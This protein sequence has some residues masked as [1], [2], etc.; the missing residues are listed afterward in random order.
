MVTQSLKLYVTSLSNSVTE[1]L[2]MFQKYFQ[3][4]LVGLC[5]QATNYR[6]KARNIE[7]IILHHLKEFQFALVNV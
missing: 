6:I 1:R 2:T 3:F 5:I 4:S 7:H